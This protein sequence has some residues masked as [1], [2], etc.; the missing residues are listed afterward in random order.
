MQYNNYDCDQLVMEGQRLGARISQVGGRLDEAASNDK[1][2]ATGAILLWPTLFFL[3]GTKNQE[4]EYSRLK[5][6]YDATLQAATFKRCP[7]NG[8]PPPAVR[9][10]EKAE[11]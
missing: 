10:V 5:G 6:E 7:G 2:L 11:K 4:A 1:A 9:P 3:G 8:A